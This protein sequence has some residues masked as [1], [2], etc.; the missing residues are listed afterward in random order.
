M[1]FNLE[2][3]FVLFITFVIVYT[4]FGLVLSYTWNNSI[5]VIMPGSPELNIWNALM[6]V[7][8]IHILFGNIGS[9]L[10]TISNSTSNKIINYS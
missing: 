6:L 2:A 4:L 3:S 10:N 5:K 9:M 1:A 8:T 7:L